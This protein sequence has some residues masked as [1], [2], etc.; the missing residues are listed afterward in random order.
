MQTDPDQA[1][2]IVGG[3]ERKDVTFTK[4]AVTGMI[5]ASGQGSQMSLTFKIPS[6]TK[7]MTYRKPEIG[8]S[9]ADVFLMTRIGDYASMH[10]LGEGQITV[11][12]ITLDDTENGRIA[13]SFEGTLI[14]RDGE[15]WGRVT[16]G[17][18]E[19]NGVVPFRE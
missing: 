2:V 6:G 10:P 14:D 3:F 12:R 18:F 1:R 13:G 4:D 5:A 16:D 19:V 7:S 8:I 9:L 11:D 17:R 15:P